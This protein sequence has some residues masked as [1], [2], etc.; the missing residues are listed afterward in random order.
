MQKK[1][2][3]RLQRGF[4]ITELVIVIAVI[5]ILAAV[6]IP[7][8]SNV[9]KKANQSADQQAVANMN[10]ALLAEEITDGVSVN[11]KDAMSILE[12]AGYDVKDYSALE[13]K[14]TLYWDKSTNKVLIYTE[15]EG[16]T[17]P[18]DMKK[19]YA[20]MTYNENNLP[21]YWYTLSDAYATMTSI[22]VN[23]EE[24]VLSG[25]VSAA[26]FNNILKA[27]KENETIQLQGD[28]TVD[29]ND[30]EYYKIFEDATGAID[31]GGYTLSMKDTLMENGE[32]LT[33]RNGTIKIGESD[34][35]GFELGGGV[36]LTL[37]NVT[38]NINGMTAIGPLGN[39][40]Q[41]NIIN[42][43]IVTKGTYCVATNAKTDAVSDELKFSDNV[44]INIENST[45]V[46]NGD[47]KD[48][49]AICMNVP[50]TLNIKNSTI[51]GDR[52]AVLVR[53][54]TATIKNSE[55]ICTN[56][57]EN[58]KNLYLDEDWKTGNE[59]PMAALVVGNRRDGSYNYTTSCTLIGTKITAQNGGKTVY[60]WSSN[61]KSVKLDYDSASTVGT[62]EGKGGGY[63][64]INGTKAE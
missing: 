25:N 7:T 36:S 35:P 6:L 63:C 12:E 55:L 19:K 59:V 11:P 20:D 22:I 40:A 17:Y 53:G 34:Y 29:C 52:Q 13:S 26:D 33:I 50:G 18:D 43:T 28:V 3:K 2:T 42:S 10:K 15:G 60:M 39:A 41:I 21:N 38:Y 62:I 1:H 27:V 61:S 49:C 8:F 64:Y 47:S 44:M 4:T 51:T 45:L 14:N 37:E 16:V 56:T 48:N 46:A 30:Y 5:A 23:G 54:G 24:K 58:G 31:L 57:Y 9:I 32:S